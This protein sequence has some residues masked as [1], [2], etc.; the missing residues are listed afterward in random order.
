MPKQKTKKLITKRIRV[1]KTG[2]LMRRR[3]FNRHLK[4]NKSAKR[5]RNLKR[6]AVLTGPI[7]K[8]IKKILG[9]RH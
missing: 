9:V 8:K 5:L 3:G 4:A 7:A 1:T 2:K 6:P